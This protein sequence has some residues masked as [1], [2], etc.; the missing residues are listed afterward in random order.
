M[1]R[2]SSGRFR[3]SEVL[4]RTDLETLDLKMLGLGVH[5]FRSLVQD[6]V[7]VCKG[8]GVQDLRVNGLGPW[9]LRL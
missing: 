6:S 3:N 4:R 9:G 1:A 8:F 2:A 5:R 7:R